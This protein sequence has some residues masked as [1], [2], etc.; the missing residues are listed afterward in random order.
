MERLLRFFAP[1]S[2]AFHV[3][4]QIALIFE[5]G[6]IGSWV[7]SYWLPVTRLFW[8]EIFSKLAI[9][10]F[11]PT[12]AEKDSLTA[13][14]FFVPLAI[15]AGMLWLRDR[16]KDD[17]ETEY[18]PT[19]ATAS[20]MRVAAFFASLAILFFVSQQIIADALS[21]YNE[22]KK[23]MKSVELFSLFSIV[24]LGAITVIMVLFY[25]LDAEIRRSFLIFGATF[26]ALFEFLVVGAPVIFA[27][28]F[29]VTELGM[30]RSAGLL[31]VTFSIVLA[32]SVRPARVLQVAY[33]VIG[34]LIASWLVD[35]LRN[36]GGTIG[37]TPPH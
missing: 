1:A 23:Q 4:A 11:K 17:G 33:V 29:A 24:G 30:I 27:A 28:Y 34:L 20:M 37:S 13:A 35:V 16:G 5:I 6:T 14:A 10:E 21:V 7:K 9:I 15:G 25:R 18:G 26:G 32:I 19:P 3:F 2:A 22:S 12:D 36:V 8:T 31:L